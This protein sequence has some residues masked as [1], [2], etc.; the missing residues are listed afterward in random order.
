MKRTVLCAACALAAAA[1][2]AGVISETLQLDAG[3][4]AVYIESTPLEPDA[5]AFFS[6]L[7]V[8]RAGCYVSSVYSPTEQISRDGSD[9]AQKTVSYLVWD[10]RQPRLSSLKRISGGLC[11]LVYATN[12]AE[13]TFLGTPA[14]PQVSWQVSS[15]G[16]ATI[17]PVSIPAGEEIYPAAYFGDGP[18]GPLSSEPFAVMGDDPAAPDIVNLNGFLKA[19]VKGGRAYVFECGKAGEWPG[20]LDVSTD[21]SGGLDFPDGASYAHLSVRNAGASARTVRVSLVPS[22]RTNDVPPALNLLVPATATTPSRW[23]SFASTNATLEAGE[24]RVFE[25]QCDKSG[26]VAGDTRAAVLAVEDLG[27]TKMRVRVP[28]TAAAD[29]YPEGEAAYPAGLWVGT[30]RLAQVSMTNGPLARA[31]GTIDATILLH[32]DAA[33][34]PTLLQRVAVAQ[35]PDATGVV[36]RTRL[37]AELAD[38]P[39][40]SSPRRLSC[41][42]MDTANR[43]VA[44]SE[45]TDHSAPEFGREATFRFTVGERSKENPFRHPWHPDH[46]GLR[47]D[48]SG[49]APS[50][51]VAEN[52]IGPVKPESFSVTNRITFAW[53]D[54]NGVPTYR[55]TPDETTLGRLDWVLTGLRKEPIAIR[56]VFALK[57]VCAASVINE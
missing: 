22:A 9:I 16:F 39:A 53:A 12:A 33:G 36:A 35:E 11:Y 21:L 51:D 8:Q 5:T 1:A 6:G 50:G 38:A 2:T 56:G 28:V 40:G 41:V 54:D 10:S 7:P 24:T 25:F 29:T 32:V 44:A 52:F 42:F 30:A 31:G 46:D 48:Y 17:A 19:K 37:Y 57:R 18:A 55:R 45:N 15:E 34:V 20:V 47:A 49:D 3:W 4:N 43:A 27:G 26:L 14:R 13:K 23:E